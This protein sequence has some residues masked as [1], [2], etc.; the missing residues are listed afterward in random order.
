MNWTN[1]A[2]VPTLIDGDL[3]LN[4]AEPVQEKSDA[5]LRTGD[6]AE[7]MTSPRT[8]AIAAGSARRR[9]VR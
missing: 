4:T 5:A 2:S 3:T 6:T 8:L 9:P 7:F 1:A